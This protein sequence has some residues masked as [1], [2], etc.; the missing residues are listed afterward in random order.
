[1]HKR[2][3]TVVGVGCGLD[4]PTG[5]SAVA[6]DG[7]V[8]EGVWGGEKASATPTG[9]MNRTRSGNRV[10]CGWRGGRRCIEKQA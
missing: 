5:R 9:K 1:M 7:V 3:P 4:G 2:I 6:G 10:V 8:G